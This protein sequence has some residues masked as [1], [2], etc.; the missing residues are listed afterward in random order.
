MTHR[1]LAITPV[2]SISFLPAVVFGSASAGAGAGADGFSPGDLGHALA[3]LVIFGGLFFIL[4]KWAWGPVISQL[5]HREQSVADE[6]DRA[7]DR[8]QSSQ[9]LLTMYQ[10]RMDG[11]EAQGAE[12]LAQ[13]RK[14]AAAAHQKVIHDARD[15]SNEM[16]KQ[17]RLE[18]DGAKTDA[19]KALHNST[20]DLAAD[21]AGEVL[22]R[23][24]DQ[25][26]HQ[27]LIVQSLEQIRK[28]SAEDE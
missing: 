23:D 28:H 14:D 26:E 25:A 5:R 9:E 24:I 22:R 15:Q 3:T 19:I 7:A 20:A 18:I 10:A 8:E 11:S 17:A 16:I 1:G 27:R 13:A 2:I 6:L 21:I 4:R 12:I